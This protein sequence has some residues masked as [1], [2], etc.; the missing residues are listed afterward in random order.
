MSRCNECK[1]YD[2]L[3]KP[4]KVDKENYIYGFCFKDYNSNYGSVYPVYIPDGGVCKSF[5]KSA[6]KK[7]SYEYEIDPAFK[8]EC[9]KKQLLS[10]IEKCLN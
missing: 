4:R 9:C 5:E 10:K 7:E 2:A 8:C 6:Q 1:K 3:H